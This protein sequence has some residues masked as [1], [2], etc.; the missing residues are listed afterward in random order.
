[1]AT[2][3]QIAEKAGVSPATVSR[4]L[5]NDSTLSVAEETRI[6]VFSVAEEL[7]Y[8]KKGNNDK[9]A[10]KMGILQW[11]S[12]EEEQRDDYYL[13]ARQGIEDYCIRNS[14]SIIRAYRSDANYREVISSLDGLIC[15]GKFSVKET[16]EL[17][18]SCNN[19]IFVDMAVDSRNVSTLT[20]D[21]RT[22]AKEALNY[23][24]AL[25][26]EKIAYIGGLE[27]A[28]GTEAIEDSRKK[29]YL[30]F[31]K[32]HKFS[33]EGLVRED[34]FSTA[35]GYEMMNNILDEK[36]PV[37]A[38]FA[39]SDAIAYGVLRSIKEHKMSVPKDISVIGINDSEMSRFSEP[40]LTTMHAPVYEMGQHSANL[41][42][43]MSRLSIKTPLKAH[44]YCELVERESCGKVKK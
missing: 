29:E 8:T 36:V 32:K 11:F 31:M 18:E 34:Q 2:I 25:G 38:V 7:H 1:M 21:F 40:A 24:K 10:F 26:H 17:L 16:K 33:T 43:A 12:A 3:R 30:A 39:A 15:V 4:I 13:K 35:S 41:V 6:R 23:L 42:Y 19:V 37:T 22:A 28:S 44:L 20:I 27:Y 5:N 14:I 9:A